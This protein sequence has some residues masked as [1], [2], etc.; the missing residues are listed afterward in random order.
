MN[1]RVKPVSFFW[2]NESGNYEPRRFF[3][4][5]ELCLPNI[6]D[7]DLES[8]SYLGLRR[9]VYDYLAVHR[10]SLKLQ[11][12]TVIDIFTLSRYFALDIEPGFVALAYAAHLEVI[13]RWHPGIQGHAYNL[14]AQR[15]LTTRGPYAEL[16]TPSA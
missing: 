5:D 6:S 4:D 2:L 10:D 7:I 8:L 3:L 11:P 14:L 16:K 1:I 9:Q 12:R 13:E 15:G